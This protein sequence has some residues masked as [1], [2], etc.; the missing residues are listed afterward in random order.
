[1]LT[2]S[3]SGFRLAFIQTDKVKSLHSLQQAQPE[4]LTGPD[5]GQLS[6]ISHSRTSKRFFSL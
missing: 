6:A 1:M 5:A 2:I 3:S 4:M